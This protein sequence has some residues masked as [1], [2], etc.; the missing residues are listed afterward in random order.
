MFQ[1]GVPRESVP[2]GSVERPATPAILEEDDLS[3]P[4]QPGMVCRRKGCGVTFTSDEVNRQ[5]D[6]EGVIC[7]YHSLPVST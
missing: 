5:G 4:V 7:H 6:G 2:S 1:V 3:I